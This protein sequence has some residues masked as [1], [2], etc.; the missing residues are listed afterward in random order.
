[1]DY[2]DLCAKCVFCKDN[3]Y[4]IAAGE[5]YKR[6]CTA[7]RRDPTDCGPSAQYRKE[8]EIEHTSVLKRIL[9]IIIR[10]NK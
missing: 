9:H 5:R 3:Y 2:S 8:K 10:K 1:M 6:P 7:A 4:C